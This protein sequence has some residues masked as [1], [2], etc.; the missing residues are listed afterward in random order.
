MAVGNTA[1]VDTLRHVARVFQRIVDALLEGRVLPFVGAGISIDARVPGYP[2]FQPDIEKGAYLW[3]RLYSSLL[4]ELKTTWSQRNRTRLR[5][6]R[7]A[8]GPPH[9]RS[10]GIMAEVFHWLKGPLALCEA[11]EIPRMTQLESRPAHLALG[12]L[13]LE[14]LVDEVVSTN[15]DTCLEK[16]LN[17]LRG[18]AQQSSESGSSYSAI[19]NLAR[20]REHGAKRRRGDGSA[21]LRL[22]KI[23]GCAAEYASD[24]IK[25][26]ES[27]VIT[28]RQLQDFG[29]RSWARDLLRDR[30]R[31][32]TLLFSGFGSDEPQVRHTVLEL[33]DELSRDEGNEPAPG[34]DLFVVAYE[35]KLSFS[36]QQIL[37]SFS[38]ARGH[39]GK[40][41]EDAVQE[42]SITGRGA[43]Y[44]LDDRDT[45]EPSKVP[46]DRFWCA[47]LEAAIERL[48]I[49]RYTKP[50][51][52]LPLWLEAHSRE[53]REVRAAL[54][55]WLFPPGRRRDT[56]F[57]CALPG[58]FGPHPTQPGFILNRWLDTM[59]ASPGRDGSDCAVPRYCAFRDRKEP[60]L[61]LATLTTLLLLA[62]LEGSKC[63]EPAP[64]REFRQQLVEN[65]RSGL[66][67]KRPG[68]SDS[69]T[70][71][72]PSVLFLVTE[73][74]DGSSAA[75]LEVLGD[76]RTRY[77]IAV[78]RSL[79]RYTDSR[80]MLP[81]GPDR[82]RVL[83]RH[84]VP[85]HALLEADLRRGWR[86]LALLF[87]RR[88]DPTDARRKRR[89]LRD[90]DGHLP[91]GRE[92]SISTGGMQW[93]RGE[94]DDGRV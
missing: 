91:A 42:R 25:H 23:N 36:Q 84:R 51:F 48:L 27:V 93:R 92:H 49:G 57:R 20:Y 11:L 39:E 41:V 54:L 14:G 46:A 58:L 65:N 44:F 22:Y 5:L 82:V 53:P 38:I 9:H 21:V 62:S 3:K 7:E 64:L 61:P 32:R 56:A 8:L 40:C 69:A 80:V 6:A 10:F 74:E 13:V 75:E 94:G 83:R 88:K 2:P 70:A 52:A 29:K 66:G 28:E 60:L 59:R 71:T 19:T 77:E 18:G 15:W 33:M 73:N 1:S 30:V 87:A 31:S 76:N 34:H 68:P 17:H 47:L 12:C 67:V 45:S 24:P 78:P 89:L 79:A 86:S 43:R 16:A 26:V 55:D 35:P 72:G 63:I 81:A 37:R 4:G 90:E 50:G 85:A